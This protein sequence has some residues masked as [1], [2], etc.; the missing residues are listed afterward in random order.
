MKP[1]H[2]LV[3]CIF[4]ATFSHPLLAASGNFVTNGSFESGGGSFSGWTATG[5]TSI[6]ANAFSN[7]TD[8][9]FKAFIS[10]SSGSVAASVLSTFFGGAALPDNGGGPAVE[11]SGIRQTFNAVTDAAFSFDYRY[12]SQEDIHSGYDETFFYLDGNIILLAD[13]DSPGVVPISSLPLRYKNGTAYRTVR[14]E[15]AAGTHTVGFGTYDT[16]DASGDSALIVDN[17]SA[18]PEPCTAG[19]GIGLALVGLL[20]RTSRR[21]RTR[22]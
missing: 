8:G 17:I 6:S 11:G 7:P 5:A 20:S 13:S 9:S 21:T 19:F 15:L 18:V 3:T 2:L 12:V 4:S 14:L 10:N 22:A 1:Y 16:G